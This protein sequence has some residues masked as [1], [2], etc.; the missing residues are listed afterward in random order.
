M[1]ICGLIKTTLLDFP[2]QVACTVFTGG[3]N[4]RCPFCHNSDLLEFGLPSDYS[5]ED[6]FS[7][8]QKRLPT[9]DGV[10]I[11]GGEPTLQPDLPEFI[12]KIRDLGLK[13][14]LDTNGIH[15]EMIKS[16]VASGL[17]DYVAM[18]IKAGPENYAKVCGFD[19]NGCADENTWPHIFGKLTETKDFLLEGR[20]PYEFRTTV[21]EGLHT[22]EDFYGIAKYIEGAENYFL[23]CYKD[24]GNILDKEAGFSE[25]KIPALIRYRD[26][27]APHVKSA[28]IRGV[29]IEL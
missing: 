25:P 4:F 3:C 11:T 5:E 19:V 8:L 12:K 24:S 15:P 14:K 9:L 7:F 23:Q 6:I 13:V 1:N 10:A 27:V 26:I 18:D 17:L 29:D 16:L 2:G 20:V 22:E 21:V 28:D